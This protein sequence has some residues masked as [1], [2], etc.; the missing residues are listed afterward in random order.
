MAEKKTKKEPRTTHSIA[1]ELLEV[2]QLKARYVEID[3]KLTAELKAL[4]RDG[5]DSQDFFEL[6]SYPDIKIV[7]A[8]KA[9]VWAQKNYPHI[10]TVDSKAAK[11]ILKRVLTP[12]PAGFEVKEVERLT[13]VGTNEEE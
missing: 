12:L 2:R 9:V 8:A 1:S 3:A 4:I 13:Q 5:D 11:A 6:K 7:D 10:L